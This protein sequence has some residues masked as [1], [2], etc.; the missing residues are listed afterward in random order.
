MNE[1]DARGEGKFTIGKEKQKLCVFSELTGI[2][3][4]FS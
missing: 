1:S 3:G 4:Y 2:S